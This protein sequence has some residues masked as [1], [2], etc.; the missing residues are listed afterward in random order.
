LEINKPEL[1]F[2]G[3]LY[4]NLLTDRLWIMLMTSW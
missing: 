4:V 1:T 3:I 2:S